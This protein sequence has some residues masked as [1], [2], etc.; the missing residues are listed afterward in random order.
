M[1]ESVRELELKSTA[2]N[3]PSRKTEGQWNGKA[4]G[5]REAGREENSKATCRLINGTFMT[6]FT[7]NSDEQKTFS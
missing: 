2:R 3:E 4:E 1:Y 5:R 6:H 7:S